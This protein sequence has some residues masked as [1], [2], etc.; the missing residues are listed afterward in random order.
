M[1]EIELLIVSW[2]RHLKAENK[3]QATIDKYTYG[4]RMFLAH[5]LERGLPTDVEAIR[6]E[7]I[8]GFLAHLLERWAPATAATRYRDLQ[9]L[10]RYLLGEGEIE[11]NPMANLSP[12]ADPEVPVQVL[13][14][15]QQKLLLAG[16]EGRDFYQRRDMAIL[17]L[18]ID[19]GMRRGELAGLTLDDVNQDLDVVHVMGKGRRP[20]SCPF[21]SKVAVALDRYLRSR[22]KHTWSHLPN[23][24]LAQKGALSASGVAQMVRR[25]GREIGVEGLHPHMFRHGFAHTWLK[26]G[27]T[28]GDLMRLAGWRSRAMLQR[29][30]ASVADQRAREA[31]RRLS[32]GDRL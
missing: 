15:A 26:D 30:G 7:H 10:F 25:R 14:E 11:R 24:W 5:L 28:E 32:P 31:H 22:A 2:R 4:A 17:L 8:E 20:R 27:G 21:G 29:Y 18:F 13:T 3:S 19:T 12:P 23:L 16:C 6:A 1:T 9:Q